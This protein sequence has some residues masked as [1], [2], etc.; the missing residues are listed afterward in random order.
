MPDINSLDEFL[1]GKPEAHP[2]I[3]AY[4]DELY[5]GLLKVGYAQRKGKT[6]Q[7]T[8]KGVGLIEIM[9][10]EIAS[11][12]LTG[13]WELALHEI[14][15]G[16]QDAAQFMAGIQR[17]SAFLVDYARNRAKPMAFPADP[18]RK[19]FK[20]AGKSAGGGEVL[21]GAT[22]PVCG[23]GRMRESPRAFNCTE[24]KCDCTLWKDCLT[25][26]GGPALDAKLMRLLLEKRQLKG[27]TGTL[28]IKEGTI[29]FYPNGSEVPSVNRSLLYKK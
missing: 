19:S 6:L 26:G 20:T 21:S 17:M 22:C 12:E 25:R 27:S 2:M 14:T 29:Q 10:P 18:K 8:D 3:Y 11:P 4:A 9:P 16:R 15:D 13:R 23:K 1:H 5:P 24:P 28:M 7:A